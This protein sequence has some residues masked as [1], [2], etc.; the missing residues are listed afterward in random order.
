MPPRRFHL[1]ERAT[2]GTTLA[3]KRGYNS[4]MKSDDESLKRIGESDHEWQ[5]RLQR[6]YR[7]VAERAV[8]AAFNEMAA[9]RG[10]P[11]EDFCEQLLESMMTEGARMMLERAKKEPEFDYL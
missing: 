2:N 4:S 6:G 9:E 7:E 5:D 3:A 1:P 10:M 11:L 8:N